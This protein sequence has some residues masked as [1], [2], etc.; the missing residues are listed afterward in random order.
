MD[1]AYPGRF[2]DCFDER[3]QNI[4]FLHQRGQPLGQRLDLEPLVTWSGQP[5]TFRQYKTPRLT[6]TNI[7]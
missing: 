6:Q 1:E 3:G 2:L 7:F 5:T 4:P